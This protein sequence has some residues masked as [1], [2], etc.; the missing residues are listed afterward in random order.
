MEQKINVQHITKKGYNIE[1]FV[2]SLQEFILP[3]I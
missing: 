2:F 1:K 3:I